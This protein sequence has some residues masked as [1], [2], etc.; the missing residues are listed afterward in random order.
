MTPESAKSDRK[1]L[2]RYAM[3]DGSEP[4]YGAILE[5][6]QNYRKSMIGS[7]FFYIQAR[8]A[9]EPCLCRIIPGGGRIFFHEI[10]DHQKY[11]I[12]EEDMEDALKYDTGTFTLPGHFHISPHIEKKLRALLDAE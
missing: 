6:I 1:P 5:Q 4:E 11:G 12:S 9:E 10:V 3:P 7:S 8:P 2:P